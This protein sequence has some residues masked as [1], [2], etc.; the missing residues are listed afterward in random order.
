MKPN[1]VTLTFTL[2]C[3]RASG[4]RSGLC[5]GRDG[6]AAAIPGRALTSA[7]G[8]ATTRRFTAFLEADALSDAL[9]VTVPA[10]VVVAIGGGMWGRSSM[11]SHGRAESLPRLAPEITWIALAPLTPP[12]GG[13]SAGV[14]AGKS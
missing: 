8:E 2:G 4:C 6:T 5:S 7:K 3:K 11:R 13:N 12:R 9:G 14:G 1:D 10:M